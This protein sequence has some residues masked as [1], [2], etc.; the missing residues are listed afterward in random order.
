MLKKYKDLLG[1]NKIVLTDNSV[2]KCEANS[3]DIKLSH[4]L[5]LLTG[6]TWYGKYGFRPIN[7]NTYKYNEILNENY[8]NNKLIMNKITI[9]EVNIMK[10]IK[11][12]KDKNVINAV[13]KILEKNENM[14]LK[15]F[16]QK[17]L[18]EYDVT[19]QYFSLFYE[20]LY[21]D[22][23]LEKFYKLFFGLNI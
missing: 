6:D 19:C 15:Y 18:N 22:L 17:F 7:V 8:N 9:K 23:K 14:L 16:L 1:I 20:R 4:M 5:I 3:E 2:K 12:T 10:Y 11:M 21:N 13:E